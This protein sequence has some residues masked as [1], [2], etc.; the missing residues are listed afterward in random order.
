MT[1]SRHF[2]NRFSSLQL[3]C[4]IHDSEFMAQHID[5]IADSLGTGG[6]LAYIQIWNHWDCWCH[7]HSQIPAEAPLALLE[8]ETKH[9]TTSDDD[10]H[11]SLMTHIKALRWSIEIGSSIT[12]GCSKPDSFDFLKSQTRIPF[13]RSQATPNPIAVCCLTCIGRL[14][15]PGDCCTGMFPHCYNGL[16]TIS[17]LTAQQASFPKNP[18]VKTVKHAHLPSDP[19]SCPWRLGLELIGYRGVEKVYGR[20]PL[21]R[22]ANPLSFHSGS[23]ARYF[24]W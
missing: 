15:S 6:L 22:A 4:E 11:Q 10:T 2:L 8:E 24:P 1:T 20:F 17:R 14:Q 5:R 12:Y 23:G 21:S 18:R 9:Q 7:C 19:L 16:I 3:F 13:E